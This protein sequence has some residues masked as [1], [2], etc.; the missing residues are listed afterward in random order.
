MLDCGESG[1]CRMAATRAYEELRSHGV[2]D[3][4]A[5]NAAVRVF[6]HHHPNAPF[7]EANFTVADWLAPEASETFA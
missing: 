2:R 4:D 6:R 7:R 5:F 1:A 3:R